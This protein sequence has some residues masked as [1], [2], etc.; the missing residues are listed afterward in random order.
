VAIFSPLF[1]F[2]RPSKIQESFVNTHKLNITLSDS[3]SKTFFLPVTDILC[4]QSHSSFLSPLCTWTEV[5]P[6]T[7]LRFF[8]LVLELKEVIGTSGKQI[9]FIE[10]NQLMKSCKFS[11][12]KQCS[13]HLKFL[14]SNSFFLAD[15]VVY[16]RLLSCMAHPR[17]QHLTASWLSPAVFCCLC[18][19]N[20]DWT[21]VGISWSKSAVYLQ[22][23][24]STSIFSNTNYP[25]RE[26]AIEKV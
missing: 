3:Y 8:Q 5:Q 4:S 24:W 15:L 19:D 10:K 25:Y 7:Q 1:W 6:C 21:S 13:T 22:G 17:L 2:G 14:F 16:Y 11:T 23:N 18:I 12:S 26:K 9:H 20:G